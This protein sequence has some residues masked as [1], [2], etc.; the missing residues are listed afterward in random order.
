MASEKTSA[1]KKLN[2]R[3]ELFSL[4]MATG[5][6]ALLTGVICLC[7]LDASVANMSML[8][9]L[10]VIFSALY[11]GRIAAIW[12]S[13]ISFLSVNW[14]FVSPRFTFL[15]H[16]PSDWLALCMLLFTAI[17]T[18]QLTALLK[19]RALESRQR[20]RETSALADAS[21]AVASQLD[22]NSALAEV[23]RQVGRIVDLEAA[24]VFTIS[25]DQDWELSV[26]HENAPNPQ[27]IVN[28]TGD[29]SELIAHVRNGRE[30]GVLNGTQ[31]ERIIPVTM[32]DLPVGTVYLRLGQPAQISGEHQHIVDSLLNH[33]AVILQR[34]RLIENQSKAAALADADR[35]KTALLSMVSH[36]FRS[37]LTS[38]KAAVSTLLSEGEPLDIDTQRGLFQ[39]IEQETD[40]LNRMVGN[41]L[42]LSRLESEA[43]RPKCE[44]TSVS[45]LI[46]MALDMLSSASN[47][48]V[49]LKLDRSVEDLFVDPVQ[50][51]QVLKNLL[52]NALKY[53]EGAVEL[54]THATED[55]TM[56]FQ[57]MDRG[58]GLPAG[59]N[60]RLFRPFYRAP[61]LQETSIPGVGIGL[62]ICKGLVE[63]HGGHL[64]AHSREGGG[65]IFRVT[66]KMFDRKQT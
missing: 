37:P 1:I 6:V 41:I 21:W 31:R 11:L 63:A 52:E 56:Y 55:E 50:M 66:L 57:I 62:A 23:L 29:R 16:D 35:M 64:T 48:R 39:G 19:A 28:K 65:A 43:W 47:S 4:T 7:R 22:T 34:N 36:D 30:S 49:A 3:S 13:F 26:L 9:V 2:V 5:G 60:D 40:R 15:V 27:E 38:I 42:D 20:Q 25:S 61:D 17:V 46:G 18:G 33:A 58:P 53:S 51:V 54:E 12:A 24:A 8:F 32:N 10:V 45:E 59:D 14:F 44:Q